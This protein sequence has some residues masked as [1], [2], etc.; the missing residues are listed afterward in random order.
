[1]PSPPL[2][3]RE[4]ARHPSG[5]ALPP[6]MQFADLII[7]PAEGRLRPGAEWPDDLA[8]TLARL[9]R[10]GR[11]VCAPTLRR[12][13][14]A[15]EVAEPVIF[16]GVCETHFGH[17]VAEHVP[18]L[19]QALAAFPDLPVVFTRLDRNQ[20]GPSG[21]FLAVM[22]WLGLPPD[23]IRLVTRTMR[24]R[25]VHV[26]AQ[27]EHL[28]GPAP[29]AAY[30]DLLEARTR[31]RLAPVTPQGVSYVTRAGLPLTKGRHAGEGYLAALLRGLGVR[32]L[33]PETMALPDQ[34]QA[35]ARAE[36]LVFAE[37]S[38][39]HGRQL[40][41]RIDQQIA[42]L[43]RRK[44]SQMARPQI[45][46]RTTETRY[47]RCHGGALVL[48]NGAGQPIHWAMMSLYNTAALLEFFEDI[49]VGL[50]TRWDRRAYRAARDRDVLDWVRAMYDP[51]NPPWLRPANDPAFLLDQFAPLR[52]GPLTDRAAALIAAQRDR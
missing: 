41:G 35:Y 50:R 46:A 31:P 10:N 34:M 1:M 47:V 52:L 17:L 42:L 8:Q 4:A 7:G 2:A 29:P 12:G 51:A 27:A 44:G 40:L 3:Q 22:D 21:A 19:P 43:R 15:A 16:G 23:R 28:R 36:H 26:A 11:A 33:A 37:G 45:A 6:L 14:P 38:A 18:R 39:L 13:P 9:Y 24:F 20:A 5:D 49:G 32:V 30:L 25:E 48:T